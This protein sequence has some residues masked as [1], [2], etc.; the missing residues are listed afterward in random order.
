ME[1]IRFFLNKK[2]SL[3]KARPQEIQAPVM[4]DTFTEAGAKLMALGS[5]RL[6]RRTAYGVRLY[7]P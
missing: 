1:H 5:G 3:K 6:D 4:K 2:F 7:Q